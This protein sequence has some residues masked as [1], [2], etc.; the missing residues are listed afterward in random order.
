MC[1]FFLIVQCY[2]HVTVSHFGSFVAIIYISLINTYYVLCM[3]SLF[4][5]V[6]LK[7][8]VKHLEL[9]KIRRYIKC[10]LLLLLSS[11]SSLW[12]CHIPHWRSNVSSSLKV[13]QTPIILNIWPS[14]WFCLCCTIR[15]IVS[16]IDSCFWCSHFLIYQVWW[17]LIANT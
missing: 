4:V 3:C 5:V 2:F 7:Y 14:H 16:F 11:S 15:S 10:P 8:N 9:F 17:L 13:Q 1:T 6:Q 12:P